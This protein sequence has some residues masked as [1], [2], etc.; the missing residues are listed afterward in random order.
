M[1]GTQLVMIAKEFPTELQPTLVKF[2]KK[3]GSGE[4]QY[5]NRGA[6]RAIPHR[7]WVNGH[8]RSQ[9]VNKNR[10]LRGSERNPNDLQTLCLQSYKQS[11]ILRGFLQF[12]FIYFLNLYRIIGFGQL[13]YYRRNQMWKYTR[14]V[15]YV[16]YKS[17]QCLCY[18][19]E[20]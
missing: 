18:I 15:S 20:F 7:F 13:C 9:R 4:P 11:V 12:Y 16:Q 1:N 8:Y 14:D 17:F 10:L 19:R 5:W 2:G 3:R 6:N